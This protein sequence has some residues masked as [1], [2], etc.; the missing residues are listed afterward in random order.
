MKKPVIIWNIGI[1]TNDGERFLPYSD[2][3]YHIAMCMIWEMRDL[4]DFIVIMPICDTRA[5]DFPPNTIVLKFDKPVHHAY[6]RFHFN[7]SEYREH[8]FWLKKASLMISDDNTHVAN[9][10]ALFYSI[11]HKVKIITLTPFVDF[12][13]SPKV[14]AELSYYDR[15]M[16][17][18]RKS[19]LVAFQSEW[20]YQEAAEQAAQTVRGIS[21]VVWPWGYSQREINKYK[22]DQRF[23]M[24][25][26]VFTNR[27]TD[28]AGGYNNY[29]AFA[30]AIKYVE[31]EAR[32]I[33][34]NP[35]RKITKEQW[36][37]IMTE[38]DGRAVIIPNDDPNTSRAAYM[39]FLNKA[40]VSIH[41]YTHAHR[42]MSHDEAAAMGKITISANCKSTK[43]FWG[44]QPYPFLVDP[45]LHPFEL[46]E[47]ID[48]AISER[49]NKYLQNLNAELAHPYSYENVANK[50]IKDIIKLLES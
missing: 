2:P 34:R 31:N 16:E 4:F 45:K 7:F 33:F 24:P 36:D 42:G 8:A 11:N 37:F 41:L 23:E 21:R 6:S 38:S 27:I 47:K 32:F 44:T 30:K 29:R 22:N 26:V 25:T 20:N 50:A 19:D 12:P 48:L 40:H 46:A 49:D 3:C 5:S 39:E 10:R 15:Q 28:T 43:E 13:A 14:P 17:S 35:T 1:V 9:W 18:F